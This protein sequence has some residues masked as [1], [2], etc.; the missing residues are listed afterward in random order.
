MER[1]RFDELMDRYEEGLASPAE[2]NDLSAL[3]HAH[4]DC[5]RELVARNRVETSLL[6]WGEASA[7]AARPS[8]RLAAKRHARARRYREIGGSLRTLGFAAGVLLA[9]GVCAWWA[10]HA[11]PEQHAAL[12]RIERLAGAQV[13]RAAGSA[14]PAATDALYPGD[15]VA[16]AAA[17]SA[18]LVYP[19]GTRV[20]LE[21][22]A[23]AVFDSEAGA[24]LIRLASG[25]VRAEVAKQPAGRPMRLLTSHAQ[26]T[27]LGTQ[28]TWALNGGATRLD[29]REG[30]VRMRKAEGG[31]EIEVRAGQFAEARDGIE[32]AVQDAVAE[33]APV[34]VAPVEW[35]PLGAAVL[36]EDFETEPLQGW[37]NARR[38][39]AARD[40]S[41]FAIEAAER[42]EGD[43]RIAFSAVRLPLDRIQGGS[44]EHQHLFRYQPGLAIRF[45]YYLEGPADYLRVQGVNVDLDDN[46]G[47]T[48]EQPVRGAWTVVQLKFDDFRHN[49]V[50]RRDEKLR[51]GDRFKNIGFFAAGSGSPPRVFRID[52]VL[53]APERP[54]RSQP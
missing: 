49:D 16:T 33:P 12:A 54:M 27:V 28:L 24:K 41:R 30:V 32:L 37:E 42:G 8:V 17:G 2:L 39:P 11:M 18:V 51:P 29:V 45:A 34:A 26:A 43:T 14:E 22:L 31:P 1:E 9:A 50:R 3:L 13:H 53:V 20:E 4:A 21:P 5:R 38:V 19:D 48:L 6:E 46:F 52:D 10:L 25:A 36:S 44:R 35:P 7:V 40:G 47:V 23:S 15:R